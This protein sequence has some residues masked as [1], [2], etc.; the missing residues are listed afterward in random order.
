VG[1]H[2]SSAHQQQPVRGRPGTR[3]ALLDAVDAIVAERGYAACSLQAVARRAGLTTGAIYSAFGNRGALLAAAMERR[4]ADAGLPEGMG[5]RE[6]V[7]AFARA[8][9]EVGRTPEGVNLVLAQLDLLRLGFTDPA[10]GA[11]MHDLWSRL[12]A[13]LAEGLAARADELPGPPTEIAQRL[14]GVL[15]GLLLQQVGMSGDLP[16]HVFVEAALAAV[17]L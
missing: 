11:S 14:A 12:L 17:G 15:Q 4:I 13:V 8:H 1:G 9:W 3:D 7:T 16:E 10:V 6:A 2:A 5:L